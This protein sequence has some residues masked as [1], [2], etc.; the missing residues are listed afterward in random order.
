MD[1]ISLENQVILGSHQECGK[2][3]GR[4][5]GHAHWMG[6]KSPRLHPWQSVPRDIGS[7]DLPRLLSVGPAAHVEVPLEDARRGLLQFAQGHDEPSHKAPKVD[8]E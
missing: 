2:S 5:G 8:V 4:I 7:T 6:T 3:S 1:L